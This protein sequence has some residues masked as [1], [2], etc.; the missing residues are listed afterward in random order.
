[1]NPL[2]L[3]ENCVALIGGLGAGA[4]IA[5]LAIFAAIF[6]FKWAVDLFL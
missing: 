3:F 5:L 4:A 6:I 1:M 2:L